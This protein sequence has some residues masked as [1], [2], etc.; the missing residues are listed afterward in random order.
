MLTTSP[1]TNFNSNREALKRGIINRTCVLYQSHMSLHKTIYCFTDARNEDNCR[2]IG[3]SSRVQLAH[4][5]AEHLPGV[6]GI[7]VLAPLTDQPVSDDYQI[8]VAVVID[9]TVNTSTQ[10]LR[11]HS[12][13]L[14]FYGHTLD[15]YLK[16]VR[17][18][19]CD[20]R[21]YFSQAREVMAAAQ[22]PVALSKDP[23]RGIR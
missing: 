2:D 19:L 8:V 20:S 11:L 15:S 12:N 1:T 6:D 7:Q 23:E 9:L 16:A 5:V 3:T 14:T 18:A 4:W 10:G 13:S 17:K 22:W 21:M